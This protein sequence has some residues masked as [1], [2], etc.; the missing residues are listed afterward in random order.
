[1]KWW[2]EFLATGFY[3][4]RI[5]VA[6]GTFGTLLG[7]PL[8]YVLA[9]LSPKVWGLVVVLVAVIAIVICHLQERY[10]AEHDPGKI[11][12]DE[13]AGYLVATWALPWNFTTVASSFILFRILDAAKP[14]PISWMDRKVKG[15]FGTVVDDLAAGAATLALIHLGKA[16]L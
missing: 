11:V 1:M 8:F 14:W 16:V 5:P 4:G 7:L 12:I 6:P 13:V 10:S 3:I 2:I 9:G 15:G